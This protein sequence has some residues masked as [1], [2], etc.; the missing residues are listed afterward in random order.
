MIGVEAL[1][2][3]QHP[4]RGLL[5]PDRF[6]PVLEF[7]VALIE[8]GDW[9]INE[10]LRQIN[11][12]QG[13]GLRMPVSVNVA[14][15]QLIH[16][17]FTAKLADRLSRYPDVTPKNLEIE[18]LETGPQLNLELIRPALEQLRMLGVQASMDDF[19]TGVSSLRVLSVLQMQ[20]IKIDRSFVMGMLERQEDLVI[21][22]T[23][24]ALAGSL[25]CQVIAEGVE[26]ESELNKLIEPGCRYI[27][28]YL[29]ARPMPADQLPAWLLQWQA[30]PP[31]WA[32]W[33]AS[34]R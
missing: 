34:A 26:T 5:G 3:W 6:L 27:Q 30:H 23:A 24:L 28:G 8:L 7:D 1:L 12:W 25:N 10:A 33:V 16:P 32:P 19:G 20:I 4:V 17:E 18:F 22:K 29:V 21:V 15:Q 31:A 2:R 11:E 13:A 14:S 9:V